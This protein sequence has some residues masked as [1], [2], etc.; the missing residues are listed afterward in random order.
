MMH[1]K[2]WLCIWQ[3]Y[4]KNDELFFVSLS[5]S[6]NVLLN[7]C[8]IVVNHNEGSESQGRKLDGRR[9]VSHAIFFILSVVGVR[10]CALCIVHVFVNISHFWWGQWIEEI[11][12]DEIL[13]FRA[14]FDYILTFSIHP[15]ILHCCQMD[16]VWWFW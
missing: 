6:V 7:R 1:M 9:A 11:H 12:L 15:I 2:C 10:M 5:F 16:I 8:T 3:Q 4:D 14:I 13:S